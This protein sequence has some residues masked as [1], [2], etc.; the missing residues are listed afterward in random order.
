[1]AG[2]TLLENCLAFRRIPAFQREDWRSGRRQHNSGY[3]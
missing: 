3:E 2:D 1:M